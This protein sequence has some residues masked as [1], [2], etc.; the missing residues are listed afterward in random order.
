[1]RF[2]V[3]STYAVFNF[4]MKTFILDSVALERIEQF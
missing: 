2:E 3:T 4:S 1:M